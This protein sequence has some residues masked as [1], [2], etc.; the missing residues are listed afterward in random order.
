MKLEKKWKKLLK[1]GNDNYSLR[2]ES[3]KEEKKFWKGFLKDPNRTKKEKYTEKIKEVIMPIIRE[4]SCGKILE[5]GPGWGNY[6]FDLAKLTKELVCLD[7]S[8]DILDFIGKQA[9]NLKITNIKFINSKLENAK[10]EKYDLTFAYNCFYRIKDI[11][12]TLEKIIYNSKYSIIGM[13]SRLDREPTLE[14]FNR[15]SLNIKKHFLSH[16]I[17]NEILEEL[18]IKTKVIEIEIERKYEFEKIEEA[19]EFEKSFI[20]DENKRKYEKEISEIIKNYYEYD[21]EK[22]S[23]EHNILA[24]LI[25]IED[26]EGV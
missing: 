21:G 3:D 18:G 10:L 24:G 22:F 13:N 8:E 7:I 5:I 2:I 12:N 20:L 6:T 17:L 23:Y 25:F 16:K 19:I 26:Q 11:K 15:L 1:N 14:I 4:K 9:N